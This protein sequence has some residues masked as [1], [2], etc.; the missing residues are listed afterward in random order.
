MRDTKNKL[1]L[2]V[3]ID[4]L[5]KETDAEH[6][7][8]ITDIVCR[9]KAAGIPCDRRTVPGDIKM[10]R[11]NGYKISDMKRGREHCYF[12][13]D[14]DFSSSE[15]RVLCDSVRAATFISEKKSKEL[16]S[17][18]LSLECS[19]KEV[20]PEP[21]CFNV[22]K[23]SNEDVFT[24]IEVI[25]SA[26]KSRKRISFYYFDINLR[27][28]RKYRKNKK[29][30]NENP[31]AIVF[32][33]DC[34]YAVCYSSKYH[35][36]VNYRIDRMEQVE[37]EDDSVCAEALSHRADIDHLTE[38]SFKMYLGELASV[39]LQFPESL[40]GAVFD[41]FGE[42]LTV[43]KTADDTY[44]TIVKVQISPVFYGWV[45]QFS[46]R[47]RILSPRRIADEYNEMKTK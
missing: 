19:A 10:L 27:K 34:Y 45:F 43:R 15:L 16:I 33:E 23:H 47:M 6:P 18:I 13:D 41:K 22:R 35:N 44:Q 30:Y 37:R 40:I 14:R 21:I 9:I 46:G 39:T 26:I 29:R 5:R 8:S 38:Q 42:S 24:S 7:I 36:I 17:K 12:Y 25:V 2:V 32:H 20:G 1:R 11:E 28:Q 31:L 4:T 3:L